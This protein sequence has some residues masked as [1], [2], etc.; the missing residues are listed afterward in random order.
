ML[1]LQ[2]EEAIRMDRCWK[3]YMTYMHILHVRKVETFFPQNWTWGGFPKP[4]MNLKVE[5]TGI[6]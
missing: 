3:R 4:D 6:T 1:P 2:K 5:N